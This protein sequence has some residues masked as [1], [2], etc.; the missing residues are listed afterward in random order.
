MKAL[1]LRSTSSRLPL[2]VEDLYAHYVTIQFRYLS[3]VCA[4]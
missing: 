2:A 4:G 3:F 1:A